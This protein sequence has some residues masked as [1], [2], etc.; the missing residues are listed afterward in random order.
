[1]RRLANNNGA[2]V[3][4]S[5]LRCSPLPQNNETSCK[6]NTPRR[7]I[8]V[9]SVLRAKMLISVERPLFYAFGQLAFLRDL[10]SSFV[11][12]DASSRIFPLLTATARRWI[13][14]RAWSDPRI[15]ELKFYYAFYTHLYAPCGYLLGVQLS[16]TD[17]N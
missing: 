15:R 9:E 8:D 12:I 2:K 17:G 11:F 13:S 4:T 6:P 10:E 14:R 16:L 5:M 3:T 1:M 7:I